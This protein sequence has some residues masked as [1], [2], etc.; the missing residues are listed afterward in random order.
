LLVNGRLKFTDAYCLLIVDLEINWYIL[1][2]NGRGF[3]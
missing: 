1:L 3:N 2:V